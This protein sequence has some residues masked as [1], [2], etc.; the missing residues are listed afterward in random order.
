[1][2]LH[3]LTPEEA[4]SMQ[5]RTAP[6]ALPSDADIAAI[7]AERIDRDGL[8]VGTVLGVIDR[9]GRRIV[10]HGAASR[11]ARR[12]L[13][14]DTVFEIGSITKV[15]TALLLCEMAERGEVDLEE[16]VAA[17]LPPGVAVPQRGAR[18]I[19]LAS[20]ANHTSAL[21]RLP[22]N[23][24]PTNP[25]NPYADYSVADLYAFLGDHTLRRDIGAA[26]EYSNL[27]SGLLGHALA[28][29]AGADFETLVRRRI[30]GP[31]G[32]DDT[33]IALSAAMR[34]R[35]ADGHDQHGGVVGP[36]DLPTLAGAGALR[37]T[38]N[39]LL[40]FLAAQL[41][42]ME[43]PLS[44]AMAAQLRPRVPIE[45]GGQQALGWNVTDTQA[46]EVFLHD[47]G[48]GGFSCVLAFNPNLSLGAV[49][50][51]NQQTVRPGND[52][53]LHL[54]SGRPLQT[55]PV[56]RQ[57]IALEPEAL[58]A[59]VGRYAFSETAGLS[60]FQTDGALFARMPGWSALELLADSPTSFFMTRFDAQVLFEV[61]E[62]GRAVGLIAR[63][64][65]LDRP[66]RR[67]R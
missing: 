13:D 56:S 21:P 36:W 57:A 34:A 64:N 45:T 3:R 37:S 14:G 28:L 24:R 23:L 44:A 11:R 25:A 18:R 9:A 59:F 16:P 2:F 33:A 61:D 8:G 53:A 38:A 54:L 40:S 63:Q 29:R 58:R 39:D 30:T 22:G 20:L 42:F 10:A 15:F 12:P 52:I 65:G 5:G 26:R 27:G 6:W 50:L 67:V 60:I 55:P 47:G 43:T 17:L 4:I 46:G 1:M 32:M 51:N 49:V 31:L 7:L 62:A 66:A 19:T 35:L 41:G 48:T